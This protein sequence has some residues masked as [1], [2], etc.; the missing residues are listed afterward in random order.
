AVCLKPESQA[1]YIDAN[2]EQHAKLTFKSVGGL[3]FL[4]LVFSYITQGMLFW[5]ITLW[6]PLVMKSIGFS[7]WSQAIASSL[8]YLAAVALAIPM[9][10]IS[11][12][13]GKRVL[14]ASL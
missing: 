1:P 9:A 10:F 3:P 13:T 4:L 11:D 6:I 5:G 12:R 2:A 7:G 8:P 14:I